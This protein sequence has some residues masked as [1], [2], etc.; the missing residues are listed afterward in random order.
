[1]LPLD[2]LRWQKYKGGYRVRY[3]ASPALKRLL[4]HG[5]DKAIWAELWGELHHQGDLH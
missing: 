2:D 5:S 4:S 3:D 1:M